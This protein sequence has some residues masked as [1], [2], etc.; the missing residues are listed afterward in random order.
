MEQQIIDILKQKKTAPKHQIC[1][2][3]CL[4][5]KKTIME[6]MNYN[7]VEELN[8]NSKKLLNLLKINMRT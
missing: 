1:L 5:N 7:K 3:L 2:N 4:I 8:I 6:N